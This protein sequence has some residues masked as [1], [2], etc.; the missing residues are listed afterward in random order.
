M[1]DAYDRF[2][3]HVHR[4]VTNPAQA[5]SLDLA[6]LAS[7]E[8]QDRIE[9]E[10]LL[11]GLLGTND[12]RI[13]PAL[14]SLKTESGTAALREAASTLPRGTS[15]LAAA[16]ELLALGDPIGIAVVLDDLRNGTE[17]LRRA[18]GEALRNVET[19]AA[20][21]ALLE[22]LRREEDKD[23]RFALWTVII[24]KHGLD[25][26][27][28]APSPVGTIAMRLNSPLVTVRDDAIDQLRSLIFL[29]ANGHPPAEL[30]LTGPAAAAERVRD[31]LLDP[32]QPLD[33]ASLDPLSD[34]ERQWLGEWALGR[35]HGEDPRV[36]GIAARLLRDRAAG[37]LRE[38]S[39]TAAG[40][41]KAAIEDALSLLR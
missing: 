19:I 24:E 4:P 25:R 28:A 21:N 5:A 20:D 3:A 10:N 17:P 18:A 23:A 6:L 35:L 13:A 34:P 29:L 8:G 11:I 32:K 15:R 7:L 26:Y 33:P 16:N 30:G 39:P 40:P 37:P 1:S 41:V 2:A 27:R 14:A 9:A 36:P 12:A 22:Q 38:R 31:V